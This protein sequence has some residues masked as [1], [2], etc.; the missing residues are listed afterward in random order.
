[1]ESRLF[2]LGGTLPNSLKTEKI[3]GARGGAR[4]GA[5]ELQTKKVEDSATNDQIFIIFPD[6]LNVHGTVFGGRVMEQADRV[7]AIVAWRHG[8]KRCVTAQV[9][10]FRFIAP[11]RVGEVLIFK[12][13]VNRVWRTSMEVGVKVFAQNFDTGEI[14]HVVS[15]YFTFVAIDETG[16]RAPLPQVIP[17]AP[18]E[19]L[20]HHEAGKRRQRRLEEVGK[21]L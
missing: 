19:V 20:R 15:A 14:R 16:A 10:K 7:A 1:M 21:Q 5:M 13:A 11:A 4:G 6:D 17:E 18:E 3:L 9:D 12:A 8:G 2:K